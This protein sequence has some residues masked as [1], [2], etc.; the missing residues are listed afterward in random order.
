[1]NPRSDDD[2]E[3]DKRPTVPR[4]VP[5]ILLSLTEEDFERGWV[6]RRPSFRSLP[7]PEP[8][9]VAP[10]HSRV[11][12]AAMI[13][14]ALAIIGFGGF[15]LWRSVS[16]GPNQVQPP[17]TNAQPLIERRPPEIKLPDPR[18]EDQPA[19]APKAAVAKTEPL[20][21]PV[22]PVAPVATPATFV[23]P[24][25]PP[26]PKPEI[27][28]VAQ[29]KSLP[30]A[31]STAG[32]AAAPAPKPQPKAPPVPASSASEPEPPADPNMGVVNSGF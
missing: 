14:F 30:T 20:P 29:P 31:P 10:P 26:L 4:A 5:T 24:L 28:G 23:A 15:A 12:P 22:A 27:A 13:T 16:V 17:T 18:T 25:P 9:T 19:P 7:A 2:S 21:V 3:F 8:E 1:M 32:V 6:G 11:L